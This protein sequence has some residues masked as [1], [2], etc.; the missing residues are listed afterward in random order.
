MRNDTE[1]I[2]KVAS[3]NLS[4]GRCCGFGFEVE[5]PLAGASGG[6]FPTSFEGFGYGF[7][8]FPDSGGCFP[9]DW[10]G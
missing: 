2:P 9:F 8:C 4:I 3:L 7:S 5:S 6:A 1:W 10:L